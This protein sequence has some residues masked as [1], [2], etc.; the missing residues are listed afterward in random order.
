[1]DWYCT[2]SKKQGHRIQLEA[3][4]ISLLLKIDN[5]LDAHTWYQCLTKT[6]TEYRGWR[7]NNPLIDSPTDCAISP[8]FNV[9]KTSTEDLQRYLDSV[10]N[11]DSEEREG[12]STKLGRKGKSVYI[13]FTC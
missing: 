4:S 9:T 12:K 5:E 13:N 8:P 2:R 3:E 11:R 1:M 10:S 7:L 6:A